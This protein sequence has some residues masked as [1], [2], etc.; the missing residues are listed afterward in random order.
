[1]SGRDIYDLLT[2]HT[3]FLLL[4]SPVLFFIVVPPQFVAG[5]LPFLSFLVTILPLSLLPFFLLDL[6]HET[7]TEK[8]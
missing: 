8:K 5:F 7:K 1:M 2:R 6:K 3:V 4:F